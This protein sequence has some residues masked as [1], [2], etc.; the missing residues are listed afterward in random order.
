MLCFSGIPSLMISSLPCFCSPILEAFG[1]AKTVYNNNSSRFGKFIQLHFSQHGHIQ[2]GRVTD[3]ILFC[4]KW[5]RNGLS[6]QRWGGAHCRLGNPSSEFFK[7]NLQLW[8][9][10][11]LKERRSVCFVPLQ[12]LTLGTFCLSTV[13]GGDIVWLF[14][15][16]ISTL[17]TWNPG[18]FYL[19]RFSQVDGIFFASHKIVHLTLPMNLWLRKVRPN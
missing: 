16:L 10:L 3:C 14:T 11:Q 1:N 19:G 2:G 7:V 8:A 15:L 17:D 18:I 5:T 13:L 9:N 6:Q 12:H 4:R